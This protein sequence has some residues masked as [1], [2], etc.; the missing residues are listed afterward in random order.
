MEPRKA[1]KTIRKR[2]SVQ[3]LSL[4]MPPSILVLPLIEK[5]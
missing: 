2:K 1:M 5:F 3:P 4:T